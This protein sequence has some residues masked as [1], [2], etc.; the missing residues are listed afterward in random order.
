M[1][2]WYDPIVII[3]KEPNKPDKVPSKVTPPDTPA[4][5]GLN[6]S[7]SFEEELGSDT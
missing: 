6:V 2:I 5:R 1:E 7:T 4:L 3:N